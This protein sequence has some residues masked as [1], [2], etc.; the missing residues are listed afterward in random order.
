VPRPRLGVGV[1][2][3]NSR[4]SDADLR[5]KRR[6][7]YLSVS[8]GWYNR[9][10]VE[11]NPSES[12]GRTAERRPNMVAKRAFSTGWRMLV[13]LGRRL[14][15]SWGTGWWIW[16]VLLLI[17]TLRWSDSLEEYVRHVLNVPDGDAPGNAG[18]PFWFMRQ[19]VVEGICAGTGMTLVIVL[20]ALT[21]KHYRRYSSMALFFAWIWCMPWVADA[22]VISCRSSHLMDARRAV[23]AWQTYDQFG[24][25]PLRAFAKLGSGLLA[26]PLAFFF[27]K[28]YGWKQAKDATAADSPS[29][30]RHPLRAT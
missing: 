30:E 27:A 7:T 4:K 22:L 12:H 25:D 28:R 26:V 24:S 18:E 15:G 9:A 11:E 21:W 2:A 8:S 3:K 5:T 13:V 14:N 1:R 6:P 19:K 23:S 17:L 10:A 20:V 29:N 16:A